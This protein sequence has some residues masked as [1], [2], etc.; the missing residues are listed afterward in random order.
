M[1]RRKVRKEILALALP[2]AL[3]NLLERAV[4][5]VD[6]FLVGGLGASAIAA[7]GLAQLMVFLV[8]SL[9]QGITLGTLVV[10]AQLWGAGRRE[11]AAKT[12]YQTLILGSAFGIIFGL[13]GIVLGRAGSVLLGAEGEVVVLT[14]SYLFLIFSFFI[15]T[16]LVSALSAIIQ[17]TGDTRTPMFA[18]LMINILHVV[19]AYPLIYGKLGLPQIGIQ[20]AAIAV[21]FSEFC[22]AAFLLAKAI[23]KDLLLR[24]LKPELTRKVLRVGFP[25][26]LDRILQNTGQ[27]LYAKAVLLYGTIA[28]A[29]HQVGLAIEAFSYMPGA[30]FAVAAATAV[31]QSLGARDIARAKIENYE[32]NRL[33]VIIMAGMGIIFFFFPYLLLRAFT[34]DPAVIDLG[35]LFLKIVAVMQIPLA[36]TM[37]LSGSLKGAGD[38]RFLVLVTLSGMWVVRLPIAFILAVVMHLG[39][40]YVWGVMVLDW[41]ARMIVILA[42]Y[43]SER[44]Q[45]IRLVE[46]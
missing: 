26:T 32:A 42:R 44:W 24:S 30:G 36:I 8:M 29:A 33:A 25:I 1:V 4:H 6:I 38:T 18:V 37:V 2:I 11:E 41:L 34:S 16:V 40:A 20:G 17:G 43:R 45:E 10:V 27:I 23:Q 5:I 9:V 28:Y 39:I 12:S 19:I 13:L 14:H 7:V 21:G 46:K 22:G 15:F 31:G 3:S 35:S